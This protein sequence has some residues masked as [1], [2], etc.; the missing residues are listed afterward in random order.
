MELKISFYLNAQG[1]PYDIKITN[2]P[3]PTLENS[4]IRI[5]QHMDSWDMKGQKV[6]GP[7]PVILLLKD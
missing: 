2:A 4:V 3:N 7:V 6:W 1:R 5:L